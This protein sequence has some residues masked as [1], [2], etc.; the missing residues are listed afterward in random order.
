VIVEFALGFAAVGI[1]AVGSWLFKRSRK[2][3]ASQIS[4]KQGQVGR[5]SPVSSAATHAKARGRRGATLLRKVSEQLGR[6]SRAVQ[7]LFFVACAHVCRASAGFFEFVSAR[8]FDLVS[9][10]LGCFG[11][12][13]FR[14]RELARLPQASVAE[15]IRPF[16]KSRPHNK[17]QLA[18][19]FV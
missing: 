19:S 12:D 10:I 4:K 11:R 16:L 17:D 15:W 8:F 6:M 1:V 13:S 7:A 2:R 3:K 18:P 14:L 5:P 9:A